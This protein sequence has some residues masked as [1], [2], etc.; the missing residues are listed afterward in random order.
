MNLFNS[1]PD[2]INTWKS[3]N[4]IKVENSEKIFYSLFNFVQFFDKEYQNAF[5]NYLIKEK[6][7]FNNNFIS[8]AGIFKEKLLKLQLEISTL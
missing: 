5:Y 7:I 6:I 2:I 1:I 8:H 3:N 4:I